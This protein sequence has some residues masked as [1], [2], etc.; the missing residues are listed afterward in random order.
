MPARNDGTTNYILK[1]KDVPVDGFW[2]I[3]VYNAEGYYEK[4]AYD[5]YTVNSITAKKDPDGSV[6]VRFGSCN[7]GVPN[8]LSIMKG[9][10]YMVR[11]YRPRAE[12]LNGTWKIP[13]AESRN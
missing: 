7:G 10:N 11:L 2:S 5:A 3:S 13:E 1:V 8:C 4:N 9:W 6:M 12:I